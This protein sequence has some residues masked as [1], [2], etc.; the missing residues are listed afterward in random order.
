MRSRRSVHKHAPNCC[1]L[2]CG[3]GSPH[4]PSAAIYDAGVD[5]VC[6]WNACDGPTVILKHLVHC[7]VQGPS[8]GAPLMGTQV[9]AHRGA[10]ARAAA[11]VPQTK[12]SQF[13]EMGSGCPAPPLRVAAPCTPSQCEKAEPYLLG[14]FHN[15][16]YTDFST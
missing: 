8:L 9:S 7:V 12:T 4:E 6:C 10:A 13:G 16:S 5:L 15:L 3:M 1:F 2:P 11:G 14:K